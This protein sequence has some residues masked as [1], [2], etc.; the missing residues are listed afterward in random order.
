MWPNWKIMVIKWLSITMLH[1]LARVFS[2]RA[3][4]NTQ[5][6][7]NSWKLRIQSLRSTTPECSTKNTKKF[8][9]DLNLN[10]LYH[11]F[12][13]MKA[14]CR[15]RESNKWAIVQIHCVMIHCL[16]MRFN[17]HTCSLFLQQ[18]QRPS[19][20]PFFWLGINLFLVHTV[21]TLYYA[22]IALNL[23]SSAQIWFYIE[24]K[25]YATSIFHEQR[26]ANEL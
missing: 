12:C 10:D 19:Y 22:G 8:A 15:L 14:K 17:A 11:L 21:Y 3:H 24:L 13:Q 16:V 2:R 7:N 25:K 9:L 20:K 4:I 1:M 6:E 26:R 5:E 23:I 18:Q